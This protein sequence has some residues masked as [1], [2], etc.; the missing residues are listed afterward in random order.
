MAVVTKYLPGFPDPA[1]FKQPDHRFR[2]GTIKNLSGLAVIANG[3]SAT[4]VFNIGKV[5]SNAIFVPTGKVTH[6]AITGLT[7]I[8][9]GFPLDPDAL[10]DGLNVSSAGTKDP[11]AAVALANLD[12]RA[13]QLAGYAT[14]PG[15]EIDVL[16]TL[17]ADAGAAGNIH[18]HIPF[19]DGR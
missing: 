3:D 16:M 13:W 12:K 14:D 8:D 10:A 15:G 18:F 17:K 5:A 19:V 9:I 6:S 7:D 11:L 1:T 4:S 2:G